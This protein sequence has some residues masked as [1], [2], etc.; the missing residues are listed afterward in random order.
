MNRVHERPLKGNDTKRKLPPNR[1]K[2]MGA[3]AN[4]VDSTTRGLDPSAQLQEKHALLFPRKVILPKSPKGD[5]KTPIDH[6]QS[7]PGQQQNRS[8]QS[9][10]VH[11]TPTLFFSYNPVVPTQE[12]QPLFMF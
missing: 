3:L 7:E 6:G 1:R 8:S 9:K 10:T 12:A 4:T 2:T 5:R 11:H